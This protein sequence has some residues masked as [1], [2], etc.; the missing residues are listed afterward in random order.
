MSFQIGDTIVMG[1]GHFPGGGSLSD[2]TLGGIRVLR[3]GDP[4]L[5][6]CSS[7]RTLWRNWSLN[8]PKMRSW[9]TIRRDNETSV[10]IESEWRTQPRKKWR[11]CWYR[12]VGELWR[13]T[14]LSRS[15]LRLL[16]HSECLSRGLKLAVNQI[17]ISHT[18]KAAI[19]S[20][21]K[22]WWKI[23]MNIQNLSHGHCQWSLG[24]ARDPMAKQKMC[25]SPP[26][27]NELSKLLTIRRFF[28]LHRVSDQP[29]GR[30]PMIISLS[31]KSRNGLS[32][33]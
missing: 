33:I 26:L 9:S 24:R 17:L 3:G 7:N 6:N 20:K 14:V 10:E 12:S 21:E 15:F 8:Y 22:K 18:K 1:N 23:A 13:E 29:I 27:L 4:L 25:S 19:N 32:L 11:N 16:V 2:K 30:S 28:Y 5:A 31:S